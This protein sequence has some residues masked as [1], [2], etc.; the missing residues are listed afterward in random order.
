M[1]TSSKRHWVVLSVT[2]YVRG[3]RLGG[4]ARFL[5]RFSS[6]KISRLLIKPRCWT[7]TEDLYAVDHFDR[8]PKATIVRVREHP[9]ILLFTGHRGDQTLC[10]CSML[11]WHLRQPVKAD[12]LRWLFRSAK[13]WLC[14]APELVGRNLSPPCTR[15]LG[16]SAFLGCSWWGD[17]LCPCFYVSFVHGVLLI[18]MKWVESR[19][20]FWWNLKQKVSIE[21]P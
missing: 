18:S 19:A 14:V 13:V 16:W 5:P 10:E 12:E 6:R 21:M 2:R 20:T 7:P 15:V 8:E 3:Q 1:H 4:K 9:R 17:G 11:L